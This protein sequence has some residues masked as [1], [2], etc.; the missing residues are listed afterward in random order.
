MYNVN[1]KVPAVCDPGYQ[2]MELV[3]RAYEAD[4]AKSEKQP[5]VIAI[6]R[7]QGYTSTM[8]MD[9]Y[10]DGTNDEANFAVLDR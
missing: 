6:V 5:I 10:K 7:N 9:I 4:V 8:K 3:L 2:P 1:L